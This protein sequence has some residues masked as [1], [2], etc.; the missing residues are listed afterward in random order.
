MSPINLFYSEHSVPILYKLQERL[1]A[2][3]DLL[4]QPFPLSHFEFPAPSSHEAYRQAETSLVLIGRQDLHELV[5][6]A[7]NLGQAT[8]K[9]RL[10]QL[11]LVIPFSA[12]T[13]LFSD[14]MLEQLH[15]LYQV[16]DQISILQYPLLFSDIFNHRTS[17]IDHRVFKAPP[18]PSPLPWL[19]PE[20]LVE[21]IVHHATHADGNVLENL[22]G[23]QFLTPERVCELINQTLRG[24]MHAEHL[25]SLRFKEMDQDHDGAIHH[26][27]VYHHFT[28]LGFSPGEIEALTR[29]LAYPIFP[30]TF[31]E[32]L[33]PLIQQALIPYQ[34]PIQLVAHE[35]ISRTPVPVRHWLE[36]A[37]EEQE[38]SLFSELEEADESMFSI[39]GKRDF[40]RWLAGHVHFLTDIHI[41]PSRGVIHHRKA[42]VRGKAGHV[43]RIFLKEGRMLEK[44]SA[45]GAR[46]LKEQ[47]PRIGKP[48]FL[49]PKTREDFMLEMDSG[50]IV[51]I[52]AQPSW[53]AWEAA[54]TYL[55]RQTPLK[56]WEERVV[57]HTGAFDLETLPGAEDPNEII[58]NCMQLSRG[59]CQRLAEEENATLEEIAAQ[60]QATQVCGSCKPLIEQII[61]EKAL[62]IAEIV[63]KQALGAGI[64]RFRFRP[65]ETGVSP[66]QAGQYVL[67][68]GLVAD[69]WITRAYTVTSPEQ[70]SGIYEVAIKREDRGTF[71][72]WLCDEA[73]DDALIRISEPQGDFVLDGAASSFFFFAGGIGVTP[74]LAM[75]RTL[76]RM[77]DERKFVLDWSARGSDSFVFQRELASIAQKYDA[78]Y[79]YLRDT[80]REA[81]LGEADFPA[82]YGFQ[83]GAVAYVCGPDAYMKAVV[84]LLKDRGWP[85]S[86]IR[87][88]QF[89]SPQPAAAQPLSPQPQTAPVEPEQGQVCPVDHP[90]YFLQPASKTQ[91][92]EEAAAFLRQYFH[93][94]GQPERFEA[95]WAE[96]QPELAETGYYHQ[97][98][99]ELIF[100][101]RLA[102]RNSPRCIGRFFWD[103]LQVFDR[104]H[105]QTAEAVFESLLEHIQVATNGGDLI[106]YISLY[107]P[108]KGF[109]LWN[110]QLLQYACYQQ[111]DGTL[112]GDPKNLLLTQKILD[113]G[114]PGG[115]RTPFDLLPIV[116]QEADRP[117]KWFDIPRELVMEVPLS[118]PEYPWFAQLDLKWYA[119]PAVSALAL[120]L[121]GIQ[122]TMAPF[123]GFYMGTEIGG[124]NF[125]D[126]YRYNLL[127]PIAEKMGL[128]TR[129][130][131]SLWRD[132]AMVELNVA[133]LH[134]YRKAGVRMLD[135]HTLADYF[136]K[137]DAQ[138]NALKRPVYADWTWIVP[139]ISGSSVPVFHIDKWE[140]K[141]VKPNY[142]Y[143]KLPWEAQ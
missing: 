97:T 78:L 141:I 56:R 20:D 131:H 45:G 111:E 8:R 81:R 68:Q 102:W 76:Q 107:D 30:H 89:T 90:S 66:T 100:G 69:K 54:A 82:D 17:L 79:L 94:T 95:R 40:A 127:K 59:A 108:R 55:Y 51:G 116:I 61:Q 43:T 7:Q 74:A 105:V 58:C 114:W 73:D 129:E 48:Q 80:T 52:H 12:R 119:L 123:N 13:G 109:K 64:T 103:K 25:T 33:Q 87:L 39:R 38:D 110:P 138:E 101:S 126:T 49:K 5:A 83:P 2:H 122:Y 139:P 63:D 60:T 18:I 34:Q 117:A 99:K 24:H 42:Q 136:L 28:H 143:M 96:V 128:D 50:R 29:D 36:Q 4:A 3:P 62:S 6:F 132:R 1:S 10:K 133:V 104:R 130:N 137:F 11:V 112:I 65:L 91:Q 9:H 75:I 72:Q 16:C 46:F 84:R 67:V 32:G 106:P 14:L 85:T 15:L 47:K 113:L 27:E 125:S 57:Q 88:E 22:C 115:A 120:D 134:A 21:R 53:E 71:S 121:G 26:K 31:S 98:L 92:L 135:H 118:H 23:P 37:Q 140:N 124:R 93:E 142:L 86:Q 19:A 35:H 77:G 70:P 41:L 44:Q